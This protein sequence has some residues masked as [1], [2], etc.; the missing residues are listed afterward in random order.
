M[1]IEKEHEFQ[2]EQA[3]FEAERKQKQEHELRMLSIMMGNVNQTHNPSLNVSS[4]FD[5][6]AY[7]PIHQHVE[8]PSY[9]PA[10]L[11]SPMQTQLQTTMQVPNDVFEN[12]KDGNTYFKL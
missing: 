12:G 3:K 9:V 11:Q 4:V 8:S 5:P 6:Q 10:L 2:R 7:S 1:R